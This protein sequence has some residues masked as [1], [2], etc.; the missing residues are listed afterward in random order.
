MSINGLSTEIDAMIAK[1]L[2]GHSA[3]LSALA[4]T[5]KYYRA[6]SEPHL[7]HD[8]TILNRV[9]F[10]LK[11]LL[12]TL[13]G[14]PVARYIQSL[15]VNASRTE[16]QRHA[17]DAPVTEA[18]RLASELALWSLTIKDLVIGVNLSDSTFASAWL[19]NVYV[20][21]PFYYTPGPSTDGILAVVLSMSENVEHVQLGLSPDQPL[22]ITRAILTTR[23]PKIGQRLKSLEVYR[24]SRREQAVDVFLHPSA[25]Q[26]LVHSC[27]VAAAVLQIS[28]PSLLSILELR[29]L[30]VAPSIVQA[31]LNSPGVC[32]LTQLTLDRLIDVEFK[33]RDYDFSSLSD[34]LNNNTR[35]L[36]TFICTHIEREG[37]RWSWG[38][39]SMKQLTC[40]HTLRIDLNLFFTHRGGEKFTNI[41]EKLPPSIK[42][43][44]LTEVQAHELENIRQWKDEVPETEDEEIMQVRATRLWQSIADPSTT[45]AIKTLCLSLAPK[46]GLSVSRERS[47]GNLIDTTISQLQHAAD[48]A[49]SR[50]L[51]HQV[52]DCVDSEGEQREIL[53]EHWPDQSL[54]K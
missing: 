4:R 35:N 51:L 24:S 15:A 40:L 18:D 13:L 14:R 27:H 41:D 48:R 12:I 33:W 31:L 50:G 44:T 29:N 42:H 20:L 43:I 2:C 38:F 36:E 39:G 6:V 32:T 47:S 21:T 19:Q 1:C 9:E 17:I 8:I 28:T 49:A 23:I 37:V 22:Q 11:R 26:M 30:M 45:L 34:V 3:A 53:V 25:Q 5:S 52:L 54:L 46:K 10:R 7:Y 16:A